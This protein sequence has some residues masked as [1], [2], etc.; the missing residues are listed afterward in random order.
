MMVITWSCSGQQNTC[1]DM[2]GQRTEPENTQTQRENALLL[3]CWKKY[4]SM[5]PE[6]KNDVVT[7]LCSLTCTW[8]EPQDFS[9]HSYPFHSYKN[10][11]CNVHWPW[12]LGSTAAE[13]MWRTL[14]IEKTF[15]VLYA[16]LLHWTVSESMKKHHFLSTKSFCQINFLSI[17]FVKTFFLFPN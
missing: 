13:K 14:C 17:K 6:V 5:S 16:A 7:I 10:L 1:N 15:G 12:C 4:V 11:Y 8:H 3:L 9:I 2:L